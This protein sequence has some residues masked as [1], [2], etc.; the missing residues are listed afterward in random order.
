VLHLLTFTVTTDQIGKAIT[1]KATSKNDVTSAATAK[2]SAVKVTSIDLQVNNTDADT[3]AANPYVSA[4]T[5]R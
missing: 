3:K 2:V 1:V 4:S 5:A